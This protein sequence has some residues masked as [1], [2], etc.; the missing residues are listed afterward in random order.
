MS[1]VLDLLKIQHPT[2]EIPD[3]KLNSSIFNPKQKRSK[4]NDVN[5]MRDLRYQYYTK[6]EDER[7]AFKSQRQMASK[8]TQIK[9]SENR[10]SA[11]F[12]LLLKKAALKDVPEVSS[13][14][15]SVKGSGLNK[16]K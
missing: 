8:D 15:S 6:Q 1:K 3:I 10:D 11:A 14:M 4:A 12:L 13:S 9:Y 2:F 7:K 5:T 16:I